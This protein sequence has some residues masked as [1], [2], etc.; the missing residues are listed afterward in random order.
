MGLDVNQRGSSRR[1]L[2]TEV[3]NSLRRLRTDHID[4]YQIH[5]PDPITDVEETL[6]ALTDL[7]R[8]GKIRYFGSSN[9][10]PHQVVQA[11]WASERRSYGR[12]VTEQ[13]RYSML[14]RGVEADLLPVAQQ[15]DIGVLPFSPL[16]SGWLSGRHRTDANRPSSWRAALVP[17]RYD[18]S[19][20]A[21]QRMLEVVEALATLADDAGLTLIQLA[22]AFVLSHPAVTSAIVGPRTHTHLRSQ[23]AV[24][25]V[26]LSAELLDRVD[27][28]VAPG[29]NVATGSGFESPERA[30][31]ASRRR[32][33]VVS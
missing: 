22:L 10:Q 24:V 7:Q 21:N 6:S 1:W 13:P 5:R 18:L 28:I 23:L 17:T 32:Q 25:G 14:A 26:T 31:A 20:P 11:Q 8:A 27:D 29:M 15:F 4:L 33:P 19:L 12:F 9:F 30:P 3:E 2:V 16:G